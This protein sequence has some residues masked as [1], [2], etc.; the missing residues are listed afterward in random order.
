LLISSTAWRGTS[1]GA[2]STGYLSK[3]VTTA[4]TERIDRCRFE[5]RFCGV[6]FFE[7]PRPRNSS[8]GRR[9][10][11]THPWRIYRTGPAR[12]SAN[13]GEPARCARQ[14]R[15][16]ARPRSTET[17]KSG[18]SCRVINPSRLSTSATRSGFD[19]FPA[20]AVAACRSKPDGRILGRWARSH[21]RHCIDPRVGGA[22]R[23]IA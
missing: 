15:G 21:A 8:A 7:H 4:S 10:R 9:G 19:L 14:E 13:S 22:R 2:A 17:A 11:E 6:E 12:C 18:A 1:F 3:I 23:R 5:S 20:Q 16:G